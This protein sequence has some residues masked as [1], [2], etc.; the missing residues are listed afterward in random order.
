MDV[1]TIANGVVL[2]LVPYFAE[3][4]KIITKKISKDATNILN[5]KIDN[6]LE[7]LKNKFLSNDYAIQTL[8]RLEEKPEG[9]ERQ[10]A[11]KSVLQEVLVEDKQFQIT[12]SQLLDEIKQI[13][14]GTNI[15]VNGS[16]AVAIHGGVAAG[17]QG[18]AAGRDITIGK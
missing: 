6:I 18:Y 1:G 12:M 2:L 16:G 17:E 11:M 4:G 3:A 13:S 10:I 15:K 14:R 7:V 9:K 5:N 8:R